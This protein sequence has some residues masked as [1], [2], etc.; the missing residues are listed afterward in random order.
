[1]SM[2]AVGERGSLQTL[3]DM[4]M[5]KMAVGPRARGRIDLRAPVG[6]NIRGDRRRV[7]PDAG[8]TSRRSSSTARATTT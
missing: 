6:D 2:L 1:M 8:A 5:R 4:Y 7:R 3:P